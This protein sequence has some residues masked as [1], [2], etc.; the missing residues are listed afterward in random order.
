MRRTLVAAMLLLG[1]LRAGAQ[2]TTLS[3]SALDARTAEVAA[4]LRCVVCQGQSLRD[5]PSELAQQMRALV[6]EQLAAGRTPDQVKR[7]F[8]DK[9][10]EWILLAPPAHGFNWLVYLL[11]PIALV[12]AGVFL[13]MRMRRWAA[14]KEQESASV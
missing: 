11:P 10:G 6:R 7:Y 5:S 1:L 3:D 8:L 12:A 14:G 9:Y 4:Q 13:V 2:T